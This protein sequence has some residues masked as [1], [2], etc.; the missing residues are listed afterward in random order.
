MEVDGFSE[1]LQ[2][3]E[4][5]TADIDGPGDLPRVE[6]NLRQI[7]QAGQQ[8]WSRTTQ[9]VGKD[10]SDIKASILLGS[11]GYDLPQISQKLEALSTVKPFE[12]LEPL[13]ET[14]IQGYLKNEREN[15]ILAVIEESKR[16]TFEQASSNYWLSLQNQWEREKTKILNTLTSNAKE[17]LDIT[18]SESDMSRIESL[19][20]KSRSAMDATQMAYAKELTEY[21]DQIIL[22][23]SRSNLSERFCSM[24]KEADDKASK[25][26]WELVRSITN[27]PLVLG[28]D[29]VKVRTTPAMQ[30]MFLAKARKYLENK[31]LEFMRVIV[32]GN[33]Q[34]A[35]LGGIPQTYRLVQS[36]LNVQMPPNNLGLEDGEVEGQPVWALIY[37]CIRCGDIQAAL[38]VAA[39]AGLSDFVTYLAEYQENQDQ[40]LSPNSET[41]IRLFYR[42][43]VIAS[44]DPY[45]RVVYSVLGCCDV[46]ED[47]PR[48]CDKIEDY[49]WLRL[50]QVRVQQSEE[51]SSSDSI[52]LTRLQTLLLEEYGE[53]HFNAY[54]Q[55]YLYF[56]LLF[57]T[58]QFEAAIEFLWRIEHLHCH[59]VHLAICLHQQDLLALPLDSQSPLLLKVHN[60][61][62]QRLNFARLIMLYTRKFECTDPREALQYYYLLRNLK[63]PSGE[64]LFMSCVS[65]LALQT[66]EFEMLLGSM[67][68]DNCRVPG[69]IDKFGEDT[70]RIIEVVAEDT[71]NKGLFEEA[72]KLYDLAKKHDHVVTLLSKLL[73]Q[74]VSQVS[75]PGSSRDRL[76]R[77]A[78]EIAQRYRNHGSNAGRDSV[79]TFHLLLDAM[80]FF[81]YYH[82]RQLLEALDTMKKLKLIPFEASEVE[83]RVNT[84]SSHPQEIRRNIPDILLA[85]M[86]IF[87][88]QYK[89]SKNLAVNSSLPKNTSGFDDGGHQQYILYLRKQAQSL[90][91]FAGMIPY[92]MPGDT[93]ARLVE[94]EVLM[95]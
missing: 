72:V 2:Q 41:Q 50:S 6:R 66:K 78:L 13:R 59:A 77:L 57:L 5:L 91:T 92:R 27:I 23:G 16:I 9:A 34:E 19:D 29:T 69:L 20:M 86:N 61:G 17:I 35:E 18:L 85:T 56:R 11:K 24:A 49:L 15:A 44:S 74:V 80:T 82:A 73:S 22:G 25:D 3:A 53:S 42:R 30:M 28:G 33:L 79:G 93:N 32:R 88:S 47:H 84:F 40:R 36:F 70:Q 95:N 21:N 90:I 64:N 94:L 43:S 31:Y 8:L 58:L 39:L 71:E 65:Q 87:Y 45:K 46:C 10:T 51:D 89:N 81:D 62:I 26:L 4:Q 75:A 54:Q 60:E 38:D 68:E 7:L 83:Q 12:P 37:Y 48:V 52:T 14:D 67:Q 63:G 1:L 76:Q 55:P